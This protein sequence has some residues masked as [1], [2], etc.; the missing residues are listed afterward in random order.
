M[1]K[2]AL[3]FV[4]AVFVPSLVLAW[5]AVRSLRDQQ[6]LLERQQSL[7]YQGV[8]DAMAA[9]V[10]DA[11]ADYQHT[12][13]LKVTALLHDSD[14]RAVA[15]SF[16]SRLCKDWPLAQV[17]FAVTTTGEILAPS[18][19]GRPEARTF[20]TDNSRFLAN[21]ESAEV[22][23]NY[24]QAL[25]NVQLANPPPQSS[26]FPQTDL[27]L[28][29]S[30]QSTPVP[31]PD[32]ANA[33]SQQPNP[34]AQ[35]ASTGRDRPRPAPQ[36]DSALANNAP[37][38]N[39][40]AV[41]NSLTLNEGNAYLN[42]RS[43]FNQK[44]ELR[45]VVPQ[46]QNDFAQNNLPSRYRQ[47][48]TS[49]L[50][51]PPVT[52][53]PAQP[54]VQSRSEANARPDQ[55]AQ[56]IQPRNESVQQRAVPG[57]TFSVPDENPQQVSRI[58]PSEAEFRQ[59]IGEDN[60]GTLARFVDNKLSVLFWYRPPLN[61]DYVFGAQIALPR[62]AK[63]L[64]TVV[65]E[66][67][68]TLR[69]EICVALLDDMAKPVAL[70]HPGFH[71]AW[72]RPFVATEIGETLPHWELGVY[73][74]NPAK[75]T[76]SAHIL[77]LTLGL[78]I[79]VLLLAIGVGSWLIVADLNRQLTLARQKTDFVSNVSHELKTPLTSIRMFSE[80]LA[81]GRVSDRAKQRSYLGII[82][83]E[84][85]RL[86]RLINNV[87]DFARIDRGEKKYNIQ[88]CDLVS[89]VRETADTYRPHLEASGFQ[90]TCELPELPVFVNGD[91]DALAQ[92]VVNLLSNAEKYSDTRK[93]IT[94]SLSLVSF[95]EVRVLDR[96]LGVPAGSGEKIF[97][98]FYR[99]HDSLSNGI[100]GSGLGLTLARQIARAHGGDVTYEPREGGG[101]CF[102]L[103]LP[104]VGGES[105]TQGKG[106]EQ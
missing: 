41:Q 38:Q 62:L 88:K 72:K 22:Y 76:Q 39:L 6:F 78:L 43:G 46:Q 44:L 65:Q 21:R 30:R 12:F 64:Q 84:T 31:K 67:E 105:A 87:L 73:L 83:A 42:Q 40:A 32:A 68:P 79:G 10:Q 77:K 94:L 45:N 9:K 66:V 33:P 82:S 85:A 104:V 95:V 54:S 28:G 23:L 34:L 103:R 4:L 93:E 90:F 18:P 15:R 59:L 1:K 89:V 80:L 47:Q 92:V 63:E 13:A 55:P 75:L 49:R 36:V 25:N 101:S 5:L 86:T 16:D 58:A 51:A 20:Y 61:P 102:T 48:Q 27:N 29:S 37:D 99:A 74:L 2:V 35:N 17:G 69:E 60:E 8:A 71:A 100:Q 14:S 24:K 81:E 97:E 106:P 52:N 11:L 91:R 26:L 50:A 3:V 56:A 96:G 98:Q 19:Q 57:Q 53:P 70:S 7:L